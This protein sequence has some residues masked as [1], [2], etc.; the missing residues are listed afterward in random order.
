[1]VLGRGSMTRGGDMKA[2]RYSLIGGTILTAIAF[3]ALPAAARDWP[4]T[5][6][7][8]VIELDDSCGIHMEYAGKGETE[9]WLLLKGGGGAVLGLG[10]SGWSIVKGDTADLIYYVNGRAYSGGESFGISNQFDAKKKVST[11]VSDDFVVDF[12]ASESLVV[13]KGDVLVDRLSL[14]GSS[15]ALAVAKRCLA[16]VRADI[17]AADA[18]KRKYADIADDPFAKPGA[19]TLSGGSAVKGGPRG[20][21]GGWFTD[22]DYPADAKRAGAQGSVS[23]LLSVDTSGK[24]VGCRVTA[25]S[26]NSSLDDATCRLAERRGRFIIQKDAQ[27]DAQPYTYSLPGIRWSL[28]VQ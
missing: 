7:W 20:N 14:K 21:P 24:V 3:G 27:G 2:L 19:G 25:S 15:A 1:M 6:G 18:E 8:D 28:K 12:A 22:D 13:K 5:A 9:L 10:N 11:N 4:T 16:K 26:G 17:A 23:L